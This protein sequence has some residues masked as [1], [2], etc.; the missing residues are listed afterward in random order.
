MRH[1]LLSLL[2]AS[3]ASIS[4]AETLNETEYLDLSRIEPS[5]QFQF[6]VGDWSYATANNIAHGKS[7]ARL[8]VSDS[9]ISETTHGNFG[10][11]AFIGQALYLYDSEHQQWS[12]NWIDSLGS[13][14]ETRVK[15]AEYAESEF[16]AMVGELEFQGQ[17][18]KHV[19]YNITENGYQTDLLAFNDESKS[20]QLIRHM[21][22]HKV[23]D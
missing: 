18:L 3:T 23:G 21:P 6:L 4:L 17:K 8:Q 7:T 12:Q 15:M 9:V 20:Y 1:L 16:P 11:S 22:Y 19:W 14:L 10:E 5:E 13:V 2:L